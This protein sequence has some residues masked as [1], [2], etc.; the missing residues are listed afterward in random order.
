MSLEDVTYEVISKF[1]QGGI[2]TSDHIDAQ[3]RIALLVC[4]S[5]AANL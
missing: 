5:R 3:I 2:G 1:K 4:T